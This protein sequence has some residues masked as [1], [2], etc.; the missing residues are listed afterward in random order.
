MRS[1][2]GFF[3]GSGR[4]H[5]RA[6]SWPGIGVYSALTAKLMTVPDPSRCSGRRAVPGV[7]EVNT[8]REKREE[9]SKTHLKTHQPL[10]IFF[11]WACWKL[12]LFSTRCGGGGAA[13]CLELPRPLPPQPPTPTGWVALTLAT[14]RPGGSGPDCSSPSRGHPRAQLLST[15]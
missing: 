6:V 9:R 14:M 5:T 10:C 3:L 12:G 15:C 2:V 11:S 13:G 4:G 7:P 8:H 1:Y